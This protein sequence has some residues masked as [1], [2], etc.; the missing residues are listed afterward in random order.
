[1]FYAPEIYYRILEHYANERTV[2]NE[3][4]TFDP[5]RMIAGQIDLIAVNQKEKTFVIDDWKTNNVP[6]RKE[7][8]YYKKDIDGMLTDIFVPKWTFMSEP[9]G[10]LTDSKYYHYTMQLSMYAF[11]V[12][13]ATGYKCKGLRI[14]HI[15]NAAQIVNVYTIDIHDVPF[16]KRECIDLLNYMEHEHKE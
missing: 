6:I 1:M 16:L 14:Y 8:G 15:R 7:A 4:L 3:V 2:F 5:V 9:L 13:Q 10:H 11:L 12:E